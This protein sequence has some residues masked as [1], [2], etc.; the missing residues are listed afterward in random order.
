[1]DDRSSHDPF[2]PQARPVEAPSFPEERLRRLGM[3]EAELAESR[4]AFDGWTPDEQR[5]ALD[6]LMQVS[7]DELAGTITEGTDDERAVA[8]L[9]RW[10]D[11]VADAGEYPD[12]DAALAAF[13]EAFP[14]P[15]EPDDDGLTDEER[16]AKQADAEREAAEVEAWIA[17]AVE[18]GDYPDAAAALAALESLQPVEGT[19]DEQDALVG[20]GSAG[21]QALA[22]QVASGGPGEAVE[23][24]AD[25]DAAAG[26]DPSNDEAEQRLARG[27]TVEQM[28]EW[29]GDDVERAQAVL[30]AERDGK[31]RVTLVS[32]MET[33]VGG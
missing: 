9:D 26:A 25:G 5:Q 17:G 7:D 14:A 21:G 33:L 31:N 11:R 22:E 4:E 6:A 29:V 1:M 23:A 32:A 19:G 10:A 24:S 20:D 8:V 15:A 18:A 13:A 27:A 3:T 28:V 16:A 2:A 30:A 12:R